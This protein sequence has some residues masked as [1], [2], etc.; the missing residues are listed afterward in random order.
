MRIFA[1]VMLMLLS[2]LGPGRTAKA[3]TSSACKQCGNEQQTCRA[4]YSAATCK[5]QYDLCMKS[6]GKK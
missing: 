3:E 5:S 1:V 6:C 2:F 4:N